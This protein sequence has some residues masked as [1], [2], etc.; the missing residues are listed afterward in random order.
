MSPIYETGHA[1]NVANFEKMMAYCAGYGLVFQP[2]KSTIQ[3]AAMQQL[4]TD[5]RNS[6]AMVTHHVTAHQLA[7]NARI[8]A[9]ENLNTL[10]GRVVNAL[11]ATDTSEKMLED[12]RGILRKIKGIRLSKKEEVLA[13]AESAPTTTKPD[14]ANEV[15]T[16]TN[17]VNP[18]KEEVNGDGVAPR[19][20]SAAQTSRDQQIEHV[21]RMLA[22]LQSAPHYQP[23]ETDLQISTL[24]QYL[25]QLRATNSDVIAEEVALSNAR[26]QRNAL[27]YGE[28]T[29]IYFVAKDVKLYVKSAFGATSPQYK[30]ISGLQFTR[31][32]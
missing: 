17:L 28:K 19:F 32:R 23:N 26:L 1:K 7:R 18:S 8:A 31:P 16:E 20:R 24:Q 5:S 12:A 10:M 30:Q 9:F 4:L 13:I 6:L 2:S 22:L 27:L 15:T 14:A 3:L 29:G 21:G 11:A 25:E